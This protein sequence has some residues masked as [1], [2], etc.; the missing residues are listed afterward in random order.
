MNVLNISK[1]KVFIF[2]AL[3][4]D[5]VAAVR[6]S[7][8]IEDASEYVEKAFYQLLRSIR[9]ISRGR[10]VG[11]EEARRL[12]FLKAEA[13]EILVI[14]MEQ[15]NMLAREYKILDEAKEH[16]EREQEEPVHEKADQEEAELEYME[17][18]DHGANQVADDSTAA[19]AGAAVEAEE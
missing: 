8:D 14:Y 9:N 12:T 7:Q 18:D 15:L 5:L 4:E 1:R 11:P 6:S 10:A 19:P 16:E 17:A 3:L 2:T 13:F